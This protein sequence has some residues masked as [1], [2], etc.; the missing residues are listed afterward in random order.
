MKQQDASPED[1]LDDHSLSSSSVQIRTGKYSSNRLLVLLGALILNLAAGSVYVFG[2]YSPAFKSAGLT[3]QDI[4]LVS[5]VGNVGLYVAIF[6]GMFYDRRGATQTAI[7][8]TI[9][10][11]IGYLLSYLA[12]AGYFPK[13]NPTLMLSL[14]F[15]IAWHGGAWLDCAAVTTAVKLFPANRGLI[16][17]VVKSFFGLSAS[18]LAQVYQ[19]FF[20]DS[21]SGGTGT[22]TNTTTNTTAAVACPGGAPPPPSTAPLF[23]G[24][25]AAAAAA[26]AAQ[27]LATTTHPKPVPFLLFLSLATF[28]IGIGGV[29]L[30]TERHN[31]SIITAKEEGRIN[32]GYIVIGVLAIYLASVAAFENTVNNGSTV[33]YVTFAL[34]NLVLLPLWLLPWGAGREN[35]HQVDEQ[36][37][38]SREITSEM[39]NDDALM[40]ST[41]HSSVV[42]TEETMERNYD[43]CQTIF[44]LD[45]WLLWF[46]HFCG[47]ANGLFFINNISQ[48]DQS[49][50][51]AKSTAALYVSILSVFNAVGRMSA[52]FLSDR[53]KTTVPRTTFFVGAL[54]FMFLFQG[55]LALIPSTGWLFVGCIGIGL[56]YGAFWALIPPMVFELFGSKNIGSHYQILGLAPA[57]GS[58]LASVVLSGNV[59]KSHVMPGSNVCCGA[60]CF[61]LTHAVTSLF[62]LL[63]AML[64]VLLWYRTRDFYTKLNGSNHGSAV[65][66]S[67]L[68]SRTSRGSSYGKLGGE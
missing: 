10:A 20:A 39:E 13:V 66:S 31:G 63:G 25:A 8:G 60:V 54:F 14:S 1:T 47:T 36:A 55:S 52:G 53:Y 33:H 5:S 64:S 43:V 2:A 9:V 6:A 11:T 42:E 3:Q 50:G 67:A 56:C 27:E 29:L 45:F 22:N 24:D 18:V 28:A 51:G 62:A 19:A 68:S 48:I 41:T 26:A 16:V 49:L 23:N 40:S 21:H 32:R 35:Q 4:Q 15:M 59:Y 44:M 61:Q 38:P 46:C 37:I 12:T 65:L 57:A 30:L 17:G 58:V 34:M 7:V